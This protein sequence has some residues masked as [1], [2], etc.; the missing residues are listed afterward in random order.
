MRAPWLFSCRNHRIVVTPSLNTH[1][2]RVVPEVVMGSNPARVLF[3]CTRCCMLGAASPEPGLH[4]T[5]LERAVD[6]PTIFPDWDTPTAILASTNTPG[7]GRGQ[8]SMFV[9]SQ[10]CCCFTPPPLPT[11]GTSHLPLPPRSTNTND[12]HTS[13]RCWRGG[14]HASGLRLAPRPLTT[15]APCRQ[16]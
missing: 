1:E 8:R 9:L 16:R 13:T 10:G 14:G 6:V 12:N 4:T 3:T 2:V 11:L 15:C 7:G 5:E